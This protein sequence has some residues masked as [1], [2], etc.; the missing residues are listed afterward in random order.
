MCPQ[1]RKVYLEKVGRIW[2]QGVGSQAR[3]GSCWVLAAF[4][5]CRQWLSKNRNCQSVEAEWGVPE[6][7]KIFGQKLQCLAVCD[8]NT[9]MTFLTL[10]PSSVFPFCGYQ[11]FEHWHWGISKNCRG[12]TRLPL[13]CLCN[14]IH[15][16][17]RPAFPFTV[18]SKQK[19][20]GVTWS[21]F[22]SS[23]HSFVQQLCACVP[24]SSGN[25][26]VNK[27]S[28]SV[29]IIL[30]PLMQG[31]CAGAGAAPTWPMPNTDSRCSLPRCGTLE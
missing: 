14:R 3:S 9:K 18:G 10:Q 22:A 8:T 11:A 2:P 26:S 24:S 28:P 1:V 30:W 12:L 13:C 25:P 29:L 5:G 31:T 23:T 15:Q 17:N 6:I 4:C 20:P 21:V 7:I 16:D 27:C 19:A